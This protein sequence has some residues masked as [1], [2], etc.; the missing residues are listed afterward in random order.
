MFLYDITPAEKASLDT[1]DLAWKVLDTV[2]KYKKKDTLIPELLQNV[3]ESYAQI[4][5]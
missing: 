2:W 1:T 4:F 3:N 5:V